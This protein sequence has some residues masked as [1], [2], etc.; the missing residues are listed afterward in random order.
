[1]NASRGLH[2]E[3]LPFKCKLEIKWVEE[4]RAR[5]LLREEIKAG[6][7]AI[8][9]GILEPVKRAR[10]Y[11]DLEKLLKIAGRSREI[12]EFIAWF[13]RGRPPFLDE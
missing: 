2:E 9:H 10:I 3:I 5:R 7:I 13:L 6:R 12:L 11:D 4:T 1:M 8:S